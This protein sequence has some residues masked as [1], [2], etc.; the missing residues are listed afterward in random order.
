MAKNTANTVISQ[1]QSV[2]EG[3]L[4]KL[5]AE[6][7]DPVGGSG[8][9]AAQGP[10]RPDPAAGLESIEERLTAI[11][12]RLTA[13]EKPQKRRRRRARRSSRRRKPRPATAKPLDGQAEPA[14]QARS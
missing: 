8:R 9:D 2:S 1:L 6:P 11:E 7:G 3:A 12:K 10:G 13:M 4:G 14:R 5:T